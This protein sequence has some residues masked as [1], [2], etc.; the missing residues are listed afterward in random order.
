MKSKC[1]ILFLSLLFCGTS[2]LAQ[3]GTVTGQ[4][5]DQKTGKP[6]PGVN[7]QIQNTVL[8]AS[9]DLQ[10][11]FLIK[12]VP[13]GI[14]TL[15]ISM[16]G[17]QTFHV[18]DVRHFAKQT[19]VATIKLKESFVEIDPV[20]VTASKWKQEAANTPVAVEVLTA[21]DI[22]KRNPVRIEDALETAAGVQI[23]QENVTIRG[24]DGYTFGVGSRVLV[25]ID[26]VP[27]M[28]SDFGKV[29]WFM[30]SPP[31]IERAEIVRGAG[32]ALYGSSAMGGV[33]NFF[34]RSPQPK[35]RTYFR[36]II[37]AY[38][39]SHEP[40]WNWAAQEGRVLKFNRQDF[41]HSQR[42]GNFGFRISGGRSFSDGYAQNM[43]YE[44]Y[45]LSG[46]IDYKFP[47]AS[48]LTL[49]GNYMHDRSGV[50]TVWKDQDEA[51][52]VPPKER[53]KEQ[54]Q[55]GYTFF[56]KYTLPLS[57][58]SAI[59][60]R[61][62][63]NRFLL[64]TQSTDAGAFSPA[65]GLGGSLQGNII[66]F[67]SVAIVYG[68]DFKFD[69][70]KSTKQLYGNRDAILAAPFFQ[71]DWKLFH[72]FNLNLGG[73]YDRYEI[74]SDRKAVLG[75]GR[76]Y[77]HFSPKAGLNYHPT[78][79]TTIRASVA[80]GFKFPIVAQLFLRFDGP[81]FTFR[82]SPELNSETSWTYELGYRQKLTQNWFFEIN[83][84]YTKV[85][86]LIELNVNTFTREV[87][88]FNVDRVK[89]PGLEFVTRG[90]WF[91]NRLGV[92]ANFL[93]MNPEDE[94]THEL[95][96]Y[97]EK[98]LSFI[99][100]SYRFEDNVEFQM[101]YKYASAQERYQLSG[102]NQLVPQK[103]LDGRIF[104]YW[105]KHS[106]F[107]GVNNIGNYAYT[108]RD[109]SLEEIRNFVAGFTAEF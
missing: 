79:N 57:A 94:F 103:V 86:D 92:K 33:I 95:L 97:R 91:H 26:D 16:I 107:I 23:I 109:Q 1:I 2:L 4:I 44:R 48:S 24:S 89:I 21:K 104:F 84:F 62:F 34:T 45:N 7:V 18:R 29:N 75:E 74:Y 78:K 51:L 59:T 76:L 52:K 25:M 80:N 46:K 82:P 9:T 93:L 66:P 38:D 35:S 61:I 67:S 54:T 68:S 55:N 96:P 99:S 30:I 5:L 56:A 41:T 17:Y 58:K 32:S 49:F 47:N 20:V 73:R 19:T 10:G 60:S 53:D 90:H 36:T 65:V 8:G 108:L 43:N 6:L 40:K 101:D 102:S 27:V 64:G 3:K 50:F 87:N 100:A 15:Q 88:Y 71:I 42:I 83:G 69:K 28:N 37:G 70:V 81:G 98:F 106:F 105:K 39:N 13:F 72:N 63:L 22:L 31:D 77:D 85:H 11:N 12:K 14:Y